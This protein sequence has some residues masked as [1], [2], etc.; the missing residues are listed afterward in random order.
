M[1]PTMPIAVIASA[2]RRLDSMRALRATANWVACRVGDR[3]RNSVAT[4]SA[5]RMTAPPSAVNPIYG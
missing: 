2:L 3:V 5:M 1:R 4:V